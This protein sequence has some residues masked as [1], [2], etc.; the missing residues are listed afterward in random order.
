MIFMQYFLI[1][2]A[3]WLVLAYCCIAIVRINKG[4]K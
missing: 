3:I 2:L 4:E 1:V